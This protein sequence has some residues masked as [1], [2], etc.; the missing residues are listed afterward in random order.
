DS[1]Q[2]LPLGHDEEDATLAIHSPPPNEGHVRGHDGDELH[3]RVQRQTCHVHHGVRDVPD[4]H[5]R[6]YGHGPIRLWHA[7]LHHCCH[8]GRRIAD[9]NL[10]ARD[11]VLASIQ[12]GRLGEAG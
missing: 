4:V 7:T 12:G 8:L 5:G 6:F 2:T 9:V 1:G 11:V 10:T 3:V